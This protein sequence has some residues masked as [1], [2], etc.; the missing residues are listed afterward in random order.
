MS[1]TVSTD[2]PG[3]GQ[4]LAVYAVSDSTHTGYRLHCTWVSAWADI[5]VSL[6]RGGNVQLTYAWVDPRFENPC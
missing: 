4:T 3:P 2:T 6:A 1:L 5:A